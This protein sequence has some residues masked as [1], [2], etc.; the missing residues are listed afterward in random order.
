M[1]VVTG[2]IR[3]YRR[4]VS[5]LFPPSCRYTPTCSAYTLTAVERYGVA[6]GIFMGLKRIARCHPWHEGGYDP[7]P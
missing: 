3:G 7:V 2:A 6:R 5:P 4:F 1:A